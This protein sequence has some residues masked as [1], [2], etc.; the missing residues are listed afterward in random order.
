MVVGGQA[1]EYSLERKREGRT[2]QI[3]PLVLEPDVYLGMDPERKEVSEREKPTPVRVLHRGHVVV[4]N[5][6]VDIT[7]LAIYMDLNRLDPFD[8]DD[9]GGPA[10]SYLRG[11]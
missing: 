2:F 4:V 9:Q 5:L 3:Q 1:K 7:F 11:G 6:L 8:G 10:L